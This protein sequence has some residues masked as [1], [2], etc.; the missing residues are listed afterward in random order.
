MANAFKKAEDVTVL[1]TNAEAF[2]KAFTDHIHHTLARNEATVT[3][4][5]KFLAVAY[6]VRDRLVDRWIKTQETY[7]E[8][9]VKRVYYLSL[10]FLIG[11]TL[12][13]SV[14]NLDVEG[15]VSEALDELGMT[16][17]ELREQEVDAG[18]GNGGLGRLAACF[19]DSMATLEL[20]ATG[21]GIRYEYG[22]FSQ[23][24]VNGE[25]E[26]QPDNWLRLPN[27]WEIAR[28]ASAI[29]V[30]MYGYVVSWTDEKG[31]LRNRWE[32]KDYVLA[33]PY[34]TPIPGYKNNTVNNLRL[35]S[36]KST[37]NFGLS[38]FNNGD[39]IAA[40]QD[41]ELSETISKVLYPNDTSM[42]G[43]ELRLKQQY[44]LCS[45]SLHDIMK[46]FKKLHD[47]EFNLIPE[48]IAI[49]LNDTH[50]AISIAEMMRILLDEENIE[51]DEAWNIVTHTFAYTNH[52]LMPEALEK[53]PVSLFEK[54]LPRHLQ[55]IYEI[56]ARFLRQ[57]SIR[58]PGDNARMAR[59]SLIEEGNCKMVRMAY[60]SIVGSFAVNGVA[61]LHS[62]LLKTTL[63]KDFYEM[64]PEKFNNKTNG[65]TPR[66]WVRKANPAMSEL[67]S[68]K[69][70]DS[71]VKNLDDL[72]ALEKFAKDEKFQNEFMA[73]KKSNKD[74]LAKYLKETQGVDVDTNT[75]FDVQVKRIHEYKR[76][77]LNILHA[78]HLYIQ[79]KD[80]KQIMPRT[81]MIGGKSAPGYWMA[82]QIIRL[83]NAV[84]AI[85]DA[86]PVCKGKLKM[87]FLENYRVSFAEKIIPA[88]DLSEQISTAGTEASG[89]GNM[90]F[91]LN[92]ALTIGTLDGANVE[93]KEEVGD[94]NIFIFGLT[95]EQVTELMAKGYNPRAYYEKDD[96]LRR[97]IDLIA[98]GFF[99]PDR[100]DL[101]KH[102]ADKLLNND[103][104]ML[105]ADFRSYIDM[106]QKVADAY[107]D[108]K[109]WAEKAILNVARMGK[110]SSDR[111]IKQYSD[112]IW[113][114]NACSIKL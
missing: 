113:H 104:Y 47:G 49:Q 90:K 51:W 46:R 44:F 29:K 63:F 19:L 17:E 89:T 36:A 10:E 79:I 24:I 45:A 14:L 73:V 50:P 112:E 66:R 11:R 55:I 8:K 82:K 15:A 99:S 16:L 91:A 48:K 3:D 6:A 94:D 61:A 93:M 9:D 25:Q 102:I 18:L 22:M 7:Y 83:A 106:Q 5:E 23:K 56:N 92:G 76:Q 27:P 57:V 64:W 32:T 87:V 68:K 72:K 31:K 75:F 37:D 21:M 65:I 12:G 110:F 84:A 98:S 34:D 38:Y 39:Y 78:I 105:L 1:G 81:I 111:T 95:V 96:D 13:N 100:P 60:L 40:V 33:L 70:G 69:I 108:K 4:H 53:W 97:V 30:P 35:W 74:R 2:R 88:A 20:P 28:P 107:Q 41:M 114:T 80:G 85:I 109:S 58:W 71:W 101:F 54:L 43:K 26:E 86:D 42:N 103:N 52:T 59:M 77:L 67:I 62:D